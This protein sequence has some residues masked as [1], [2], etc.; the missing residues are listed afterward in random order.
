ME[1]EHGG[2]AWKG[3]G[4]R[5][6]G[7]GFAKR[8]PEAMRT[9]TADVRGPFFSGFTRSCPRVCHQGNMITFFPLRSLVL[10]NII[11][12]KGGGCRK[13]FIYTARKGKNY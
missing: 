2:R 9:P 3:H 1:S 6:R 4:D 12:H 7:Q 10:K 8:G 11:S 5:A 13:I